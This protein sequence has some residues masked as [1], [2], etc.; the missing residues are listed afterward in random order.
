M[1]ILH[2]L[3]KNLFNI[4]SAVGVLVAAYFS[5][6]SAKMSEQA[7]KAN[8]SPLIVPSTISYIPVGDH[9]TNGK[10]CESFFNIIIENRTEYKNA[11]AKNISIKIENKVW[12]KIESLNPS[13][14]CDLNA[15]NKPIDNFI[16]KLVQITYEDI[17][18]NKFK[19]ECFLADKVTKD[20]LYGDMEQTATHINFHWCYVQ[21]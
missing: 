16:S 6:R 4:L 18:G 1:F 13:Q 2:S 14:S 19:T 8:F 17:L 10:P 15:N 7:N 11:F 9:L 5:Y 3:N 12:W 20:P 21:I